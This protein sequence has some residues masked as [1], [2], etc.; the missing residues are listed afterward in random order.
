MARRKPPEV[1]TNWFDQAINFVDP[2]LGNKRYAARLVQAVYGGYEGGK[3]DRRQTKNWTPGGGS[4]D[5]DILPDLETIR[6]RTRDLNRNNALA[7]GAL[8]TKVTN[9]V[10]TGIRLQ[11]CIDAEAL[12]M[13]EE[14][15]DVWQAQ[16]EREFALWAES[17]E[18]DAE[19]TLSFVGLQ[20]LAF[21][22]TLENGDVFINLPFIKRP[23]SPYELKIQ[24]I[25]ADRVCNEG[26][27]ADTDQLAGGVEK[28]EYGAPIR[29]HVLKTH[30][31]AIRRESQEWIKLPAFGIKT[32]RRNVLHLFWKLRPG[33]SRGV[34]DL[35][36]VIE[37]FKQ[38]GDYSDAEIMAAVV[39]AMFTVFFKSPDG[40]SIPP[41]TP[42]SETGGKADDDDY[43][44]GPAAMLDLAHGEEVEFANPMRPN[45]QYGAFVQSVL[46]Q[47]GVALELPYEVLTKHFTASYSAARAA[48]NEAWKFFSMQ[49]AWLSE[50][51]CQPIYEAWLTEAVAT[52]R[53]YAPGFLNGDPI[54]RKAYCGAL[55]I[56]PARGQIDPL[57]EA[58]ASE[59]EINIG[60]SSLA[61]EAA[62]R[63]RDF[64]TLH[65]QRAKEKRM[66]QE[67]GLEQAIPSPDLTPEEENSDAP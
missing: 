63:G 56:G 5:A 51:F 26:M 14:Q 30:P 54:I 35:A 18:C 11:S 2:I 50:N 15:A 58:K 42:G 27:L 23:G 43:K 45:S 10:G 13:T 22:S 65:R 8:R 36:P 37:A 6:N 21:L 7:S 52:G 34:P 61:I 49:R 33:Q 66:R 28:D 25:E 39:S 24:L 57:K 31:G 3:K 62:E 38:L 32:G 40:G 44:L 12:G 16:V 9:T 47:V 59:L 20:R 17:Q 48:L 46:E 67:A 29:Y 64:E 60:T 41:M 55:W 53:V 1:K 4:A 19:R